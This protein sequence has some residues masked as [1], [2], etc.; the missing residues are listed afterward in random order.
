MEKDLK[1]CAESKYSYQHNAFVQIDCFFF[2]CFFFSFHKYASGFVDFCKGDRLMNDLVFYILYSSILVI[3]RRCKG[4]KENLWTL[5]YGS[6]NFR[7][8][9][10]AGIELWPLAKQVRTKSSGLL[11]HL[12]N[13]ITLIYQDFNP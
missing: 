8:L 11:S 1:P 6:K 9:P 7:F 4:D 5:I 3:S 12:F 2:F 10:P 13:P